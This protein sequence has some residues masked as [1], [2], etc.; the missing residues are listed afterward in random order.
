[1]SQDNVQTDTPQETSNEQEF[2]SLEEAIFGSNEGSGSNVESAFTAGT[3]NEGNTAAPT[4]DTI[5]QPVEQTPQVENNDETRYQYWQSTADKLKNENEQLRRNIAENSQQ[6]V[7][8]QQQ[9]Q[10]Q[11]PPIDESFPPPPEKPARPRAF[12]REEAYAD[13][14]S[15]SA[16]YLDEIDDWRDN[17]SEY[18]ALKSQYDQA[19]ITEKFDRMD[20]QKRDEA[21]RVQA[22]QQEVAQKNEIK[23]HVMGAYGMTEPEA[24]DFMN[25]MSDP[26]S[27]NIDNLVKLYRIEQGGGSP[28]PV[29]PTPSPSF[30]QVQNAQQVPSPMGVMPSGQSNSDNRTV[31]DKI[32]DTM[33]GNFNKKNPWK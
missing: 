32:M 16:R 13:P 5:G 23:T 20:Q 28:Q 30:Q 14:S 31:E 33:I 24:V 15:E 18:N 19:V 1:M 25:K 21:M 8:N 3:E 6:A 11:E 22:R 29:A 2:A 12:N 7:E 27:L 4:N 9:A 10:N 17:V 26:K